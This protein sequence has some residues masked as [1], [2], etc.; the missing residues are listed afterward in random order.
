MVIFIEMKKIKQKPSRLVIKRIK[1]KSGADVV[2]KKFSE[3]K[4]YRT[5]VVPDKK[6][7]YKIPSWE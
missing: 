1:T 6:K 4:E 2:A 7:D 3:D 5:R